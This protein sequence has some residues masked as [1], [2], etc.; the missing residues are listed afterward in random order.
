MITLMSL[1]RVY[2]RLHELQLQ[3]VVINADETP[4]KVIHEDKRKCYMW[5]YCTGTD[6]PP[7]HAEGHLNKPPNIV[8][9]DYQNSR[10]GQCVKDYLQG[11]SGYLQV[12]GYAGYQASSE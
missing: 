9:Y 8:L 4:L 3:Q 11:F 2:Q 7:D 1:N 10:R 12:D 5:V 6:S